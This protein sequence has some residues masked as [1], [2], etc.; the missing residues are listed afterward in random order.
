MQRYVT[1]SI[2]DAYIWTYSRLVLKNS[3]CR[4]NCEECGAA[5]FHCADR[6]FVV[7]IGLP[8]CRAVRC[9]QPQLHACL[10][11]VVQYYLKYLKAALV[12]W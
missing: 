6:S 5:A 10:A 11:Q 2:N 9:I 3:R 4:A 7:P 8:L 1:Y 12:I